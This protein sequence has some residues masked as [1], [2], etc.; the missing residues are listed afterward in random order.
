MR[1]Y[2]KWVSVNRERERLRERERRNDKDEEWKERKKE[3][4]WEREI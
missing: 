1:V 3:C 2:E 4:V